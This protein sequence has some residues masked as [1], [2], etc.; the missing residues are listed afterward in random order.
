MSEGKCKKEAADNQWK[1]RQDSQGG[2]GL[3]SRQTTRVSE[4][5]AAGESGRF[6]G[7]RE[8]GW[9]RPVEVSGGVP[10]IACGA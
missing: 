6:G 1:L 5:D 10:F 8:F 4:L 3:G 7:R 9:F 2:L